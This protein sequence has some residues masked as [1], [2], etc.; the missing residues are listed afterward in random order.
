MISPIPPLDD[1]EDT[2]YSLGDVPGKPWL[3]LI[4]LAVY[5]VTV[6]PLGVLDRVGWKL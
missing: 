2:W 1:I 3:I 6:W 4:L 5:V